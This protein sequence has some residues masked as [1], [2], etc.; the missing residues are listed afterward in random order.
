MGTT[1]TLAYVVWPHVDLVHVGDSRAYLCR[2]GEMI[3]SDSRSDLCSSTCGRRSPRTGADCKITLNHVLFSLL[4]CEPKQLEPQVYKSTLSWNDTLLLC[5]DGLTRHLSTSQIGEILASGECAQVVTNQLINSA[6]AA[7][8]RDNTT[9][10]VAKFG[11]TASAA[12]ARQVGH[13][14][15]SHTKH[16][17]N[18]ETVASMLT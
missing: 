17:D 11:D 12:E 4:G 3:L 16:R 14:S 7:G 18:V 2:N 13:A 6:N 8:S 5:T 9:V 10:I 15:L 1:I